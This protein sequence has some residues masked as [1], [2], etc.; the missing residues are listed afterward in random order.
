[1]HLTWLPS[2]HIIWGC[3]AFGWNKLKA[4][5]KWLYLTVLKGLSVSCT[6]F[7]AFQL[8]LSCTATCRLG[9]DGREWSTSTRV[10]PAAPARTFTTR[11]W[12][13]FNYAHVERLRIATPTSTNHT[14]ESTHRCADMPTAI[15]WVQNLFYSH[16]FAC[17]NWVNSSNIFF[18]PQVLAELHPKLTIYPFEDLSWMAQRRQGTNAGL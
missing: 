16:H 11:P 4:L 12:A 7:L 9:E 8:D 18:G 3:I 5:T 2:A 10:L 15:R 13:H 14:S 6:F 17:R 1:M